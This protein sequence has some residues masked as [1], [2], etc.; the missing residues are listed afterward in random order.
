MKRVKKWLAALLAMIM[1]CTPAMNVAAAEAAYPTVDMFEQATTIKGL[2]GATAATKDSYGGLQHS[3]V[4]IFLDDCI[5]S[6]DSDW[7][8]NG[9]VAPFTFEGETFYFGDSPAGIG[10]VENCN[11]SDMSISIVF[12]LRWKTDEYNNDSSFLID[13]GSRVPG[14]NYYAPN[15]D[16]ST[17]GGRA[18]RAYWYFLM[19]WCAKNN[20]HIDNLILGNEVNMPNAWHYSGSTDPATVA[21]KYAD[22]FYWMY[23]EVRKFT[24][25]TR[26]SISVD[27]SWNHNDEGRGIT[28]RD[29]LYYFDSRLKSKGAD[30]DW[31]LS[32]HLYP[33]VLTE[34]KIWENTYGFGLT[35]NSAD[36]QMVDGSNLSAVTG[37]IRDTYG[38]EHRVMLTEQGFTD[39]Q[40]YDVQAASLAYTYYAAMYDP[41]VDSF[42][43]NVEYSGDGLNFGIAGK[44][45]GDV[46][47]KIGN[48]NAA[49][50][51]WIADLCLP[52]IGVSSWTEIVPHYGQPVDKASRTYSGDMCADLKYFNLRQKED[53]S[54]YLAGEILINEV[55]GGV[56]NVPRETPIMGFM[57]ADSVEYMEVTMTANGINYYFECP[58]TGLTEGREYVLI[59]T[60][61]SAR[62]ISPNRSIHVNLLTS[63]NMPSSG[64]LGTTENQWIA[65]FQ[66]DT[67][68]MRV[69]CKDLLE[70]TFLRKKYR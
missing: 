19:D 7:A 39:A 30:V 23:S 16:L 62:N 42:L 58:I 28:V 37:Y 22:A 60:S 46:Y 14:Y 40:G 31:C 61:G 12:L 45:A 43:L 27:H 52:V 32:M 41:M 66:S 53:G 24:D 11:N 1:L 68:V 67:G 4:N 48:G 33:A 59:V 47:T 69:Y 3:L 64:G 25:V 17:Y 18:I 56:S 13:A 2:Q 38:E 10:F 36:T 57:S 49:D 5:F 15:S 70:E 9:W 55:I 35:T 51:Q 29:F 21:N 44:L 50:Q 8:K 20:Y 26:C 6:P 63:P 34:P 65:Y 54:Y